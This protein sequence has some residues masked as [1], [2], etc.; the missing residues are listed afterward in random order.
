MVSPTDPNV[1]GRAPVPWMWPFRPNAPVAAGATQPVTLTNGT[2]PF[3]V[4]HL[5]FQSLLVGV[6]LYRPDFLISVRDT[7]ADQDLQFAPYHSNMLGDQTQP[8]FKLPTPWVV[9]DRNS[10]DVVFTNIDLLAVVPELDLIGFL[11]TWDE[12]TMLRGEGKLMWL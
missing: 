6:P 8:P 5:K 1:V 4:T 2:R 11:S 12:I 3:V 7:G 10:I 9:T